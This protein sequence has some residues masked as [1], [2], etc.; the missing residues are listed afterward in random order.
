MVCHNCGKEVAEGQSFCPS[1]GQRAIPTQQLDTCTKCGATIE[2]DAKFCPKCGATAVFQDLKCRSCEADIPFGSKFCPKCGTPSIHGVATFTPPTPA[3]DA[4]AD[5]VPGESDNFQWF[6]YCLKQKYA[7]FNGRARRKEYWWYALFQYIA[8]LVIGFIPIIGL[9]AAL[10]L[11]VPSLAVA[12]RRLHDIGKSGWNMLLL[13]I[14]FVGAILLLI[15]LTRDS[16]PGTNQYGPN[17]K[18]V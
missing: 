4:H 6:I 10:A 14:P 7:D 18:G 13:L 2:P 9:L 16:A 12:V 11:I 8:F 1:C 3:S 15:F 5:G 17:P